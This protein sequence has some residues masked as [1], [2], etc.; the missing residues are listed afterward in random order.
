MDL[1]KTSTNFRIDEI[2]Y[3]KT[4]IIAKNEKRSINSQLE[5][6]VIKGVKEYENLNGEIIVEE[7]INTVISIIPSDKNA[8]IMY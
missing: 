1:T 3:K 5:Y 2:A 6:F 8:E 4:K 7:W